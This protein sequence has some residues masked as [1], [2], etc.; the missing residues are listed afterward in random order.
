[1]LDKSDDIYMLVHYIEVH[2]VV[3]CLNGTFTIYLAT[4]C[5]NLSALTLDLLLNFVFGEDS[6]NVSVEI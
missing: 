1:M 5:I 6:K 2:Q 3:S 4:V